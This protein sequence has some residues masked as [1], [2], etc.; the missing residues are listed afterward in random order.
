MMLTLLARIL[1]FFFLLYV[2]VETTY[3]FNSKNYI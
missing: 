3:A 1:Y 2:I